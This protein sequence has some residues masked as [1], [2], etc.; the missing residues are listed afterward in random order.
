MKRVWIP[1]YQEQPNEALK[2]LIRSFNDIVEALYFPLLMGNFL[3][4]TL[5]GVAL[6]LVGGWAILGAAAL[7]L[8]GCRILLRILEMHVGWRKVAP[9]NNNIYGPLT[10]SISLALAISLALESHVFL[11]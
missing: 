3:G 4:S 9:L 8:N 2:Q 10:I 7:L 6:L 1:A 5:L 11:R